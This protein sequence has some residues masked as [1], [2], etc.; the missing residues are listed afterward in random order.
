MEQE[1]AGCWTDLLDY[2]YATSEVWEDQELAL[3]LMAFLISRGW[4]QTLGGTEP[5]CES[6]HGATSTGSPKHG[7]NRSRRTSTTLLRVSSGLLKGHWTA[8]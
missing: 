3:A 2:A 6:R 8:T 7:T 4:S 5:D 1:H